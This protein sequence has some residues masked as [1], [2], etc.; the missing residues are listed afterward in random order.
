LAWALRAAGHEV[1]L[2][3]TP[4]WVNDMA[5]T[6]LPVV[7]VGGSPRVTRQERDALG[8]AVFTQGQWPAN[9]VA[10]IDRLDEAK[11]AHLNAIG[12]Y[13]VAAAEAMVDDTVAFAREWMPDV[14]VYDSFSYAGA[15]AAAAID[16]P[17]VRHLTGTDSAQRLE[18]IQPSFEPRPD[19]VALFERFGIPVRTEAMS[20]VDP[21]PPSMRLVT[22]DR[23]LSMRYVPYNGPGTM[24][25]GLLDGRSRPRICVTWGHTIP[26]ATGA[27]GAQ[28]FLQAIEMITDLGMD[29]LVAAPA[30]AIRELGPL[31]DSVRP[32][33]SVPLN[34]VLPYCDAIVHQGGDGTALTAAGAAIPQLAITASH[35]AHLCGSRLGAVSA[36]IFLRDAELRDDPD[37][38]V[39]IRHAVQ[40]LL[41]EPRFADGAARLRDEIESQPA[42]AEVAAHLADRVSAAVSA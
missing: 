36:G 14:V 11:L 4:K 25:E 6:G 41:S 1:R 7:R 27:A 33:A 20:T 23:L 10:H 40:A 5:H 12:R 2:A 38:A 42:P 22:P 19:Y 30:E 32:L 29:C 28:P 37:S 13:Q 3:G 31:P 21:T 8:V 35:E 34:I 24:P 26:G 17:G 9:W 15:V 18:L 39:I 16:V